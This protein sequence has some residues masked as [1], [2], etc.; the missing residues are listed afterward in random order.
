MICLWS[1]CLFSV[2]LVTG[3]LHVFNEHILVLRMVSSGMLC[4]VALVRTDAACVG[5]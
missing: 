5:C 3:A 4:R 2:V 1:A